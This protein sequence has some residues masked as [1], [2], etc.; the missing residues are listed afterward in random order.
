MTLDNN[1]L[2]KL[3][4]F[5]RFILK[6]IPLPSTNTPSSDN[7]NGSTGSSLEYARSDHQH[8]KSTLYAESVHSH[9]DILS[10][11]MDNINN[12][13]IVVDSPNPIGQDGDTILLRGRMYGDDI[14]SKSI[15][16]YIDNTL[17]GS[18]VTNSNGV[19]FLDYECDGLGVR[20]VTAKNGSI[21]SETFSVLDCM[22]C[23]MCPTS[24]IKWWNQN[25]AINISTDGD[26]KVLTTTASG[27]QYRPAT[28]QTTDSTK[29]ISFSPSFIC[30]FEVTEITG[31]WVLQTY[32]GSVNQNPY[33]STTGRYKI[34]YDGETAKYYK[35]DATSP[36]SQKSGFTG[37]DAMVGFQC[38]SSGQTLKYKDFK[39]YPI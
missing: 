12:T 23:D 15:D 7:T 18:S 2:K 34:V 17:I 8:P 31:S 9:N 25:S 39:I 21:V 38:W 36:F 14:S 37:L 22:F 33:I 19:S 16:Y 29:V 26:V 20:N 11:L 27:N 1:L 5:K 10:D 13:T 24:N 3:E 4:N 35:D 28:E 32:D 6:S 30:E